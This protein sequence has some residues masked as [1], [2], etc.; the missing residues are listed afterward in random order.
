MLKRSKRLA[1]LGHSKCR[2]V[3]GIRTRTAHCAEDGGMAAADTELDWV[4]ERLLNGAIDIIRC[5]H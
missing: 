5:E 1:S 2:C 3:S 4:G